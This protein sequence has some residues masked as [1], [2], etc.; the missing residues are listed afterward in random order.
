MGAI[1]GGQIG[2]FNLVKLAEDEI[3]NFGEHVRVVFEG[4]EFTNV[5]MGRS[6]RR[7]ATALQ[8]LKVKRGD[9]VLIQMANCPEVFQSFWAIW[10]I[11]AIVVPVNHMI[12]SEESACIYYDCGAETLISTADFLPRIE[13]CR[14]KTQALRNVIL[15]DRKVPENCL[16]YWELVGECPEETGI[17]RTDGDEVAA[18]VYTAGTTG[19]PKGVMHSH[20]S[21]YSIAKMLND[22]VSLPEETVSV[23]V[24]PL[25][26]IY[27]LSCSIAGAL[28]GGLKA[29]VLPSFNVDKIFGCIEAYKANLFVGV[30]TLYVY[31]L[32]HPDPG[33]Y[34][35]SSMRWWISGSAP[36]SQE[37]WRGFKEKFGFEIIEGWGL[38]EIGASGCVNPLGGPKKVGSIGRPV[39][40][41]QIKIID[42]DGK[43]LPQGQPGEIVI[44]SPGV[45]KGYW[46]MPE[47]TAEVLRD[48]WIHTG[49]IGYVDDDGYYFITDRKKDII[50]KGGEN[51]SPREIEEVIVTHPKVCEAAVVGIKDHIYGEDIKAF[52]VL[53]AGEQTTA[54]ELK[55]YCCGRLKRFKTPKEF[56]FVDALPKNLVGKVLRKELRRMAQ[57]PADGQ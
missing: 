22:S 30:P 29:V 44:R 25:C 5:E 31:M 57:S 7:L 50:I 12:G 21:L 52:V 9:R 55:E 32:L 36:L 11:G 19:K 35:L 17:A 18:V 53:K 41:A 46:N 6:A 42:S 45:M 20:Y 2:T 1:M 4:Q 33:K 39:K 23:F 26:H 54:D 24:L 56:V 43:E 51:I 16:S 47:E 38:T 48:G 28:K 13:I 10:R 37:T 14:T 15:I 8:R 34:D 49:D 3:K 27:G 40:D